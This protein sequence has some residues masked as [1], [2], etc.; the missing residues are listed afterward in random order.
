MSYVLSGAIVAIT[1]EN[2]YIIPVLWHYKMVNL[3]TV[4][5]IGWT[6]LFTILA[7]TL[8]FPNNA[9]AQQGPQPHTVIINCADVDTN[10]LPQ[11]PPPP[12]NPD[13][14]SSRATLHYAVMDMT[15]G[16]ITSSGVIQ[17]GAQG[18]NPNGN[19]WA[20]FV[21][22]IALSPDNS[23]VVVNVNDPTNWPVCVSNGWFLP[24]APE[25]PDAAAR[26]AAL[27]SNMTTT[28]NAT[29]Q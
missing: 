6:A 15:N 10:H 13:A 11:N 25:A 2:P 8:V 16:Q 22:D 20:F 27:P 23:V 17:P 9:F 1:W 21:T 14:P 18:W 3:K 26:S 4:I 19:T 12:Q 29:S 5:A 28:S 24:E 7:G